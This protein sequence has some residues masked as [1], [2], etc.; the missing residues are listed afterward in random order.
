MLLLLTAV[1]WWWARLWWIV[2]ES[3]ELDRHNMVLPSL[4]G[5]H[6]LW[7]SD[8]RRHTL[9]IH[10]LSIDYCAHCFNP[11]W[12][13]I[14]IHHRSAES[15]DWMIST[16]NKACK[17][18]FKKKWMNQSKGPT[19]YYSSHYCINAMKQYRCVAKI[20]ITLYCN[21]ANWSLFARNVLNHHKNENWWLML[22]VCI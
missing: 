18:P 10:D 16:T 20:Q 6:A 4:W 12:T 11:F 1:G 17:E 9:W 15:S 8:V 21:M 13:C 7:S 14:C 19:T 3:E 2:L 5:L 22:F